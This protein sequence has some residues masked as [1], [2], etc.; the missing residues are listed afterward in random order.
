MQ[1]KLPSPELPINLAITEALENVVLT[2]TTLKL[3]LKSQFLTF[4]SARIK[5]MMSEIYVDQGTMA[6]SAWTSFIYST[7]D[8]SDRYYSADVRDKSPWKGS[9]S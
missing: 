9:F 3:Q 2:E 5:D 1:P 4:F 6:P 7:I 8:M